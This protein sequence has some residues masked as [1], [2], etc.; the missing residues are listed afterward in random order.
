L[1]QEA[2]DEIKKKKES[3]DEFEFEVAKD[4]L[5][6]WLRMVDSH[7]ILRRLVLATTHPERTPV[8]DKVSLKKLSNGRITVVGQA[9][10]P[11]IPGA[12]ISGNEC[13]QDARVLIESLKGK[14]IPDEIPL[15]LK[16]YSDARLGP[17]TLAQ[18]TSRQIT[19]MYTKAA[20]DW[21][22][23]MEHELAAIVDFPIQ[24]LAPSSGYVHTHSVP[25]EEPERS[26]PNS[27]V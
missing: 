3:S 2:A 6:R 7:E 4:A 11:L 12:F 25:I 10:H 27:R 21:D 26:R 1:A 15:A 14:N 13:V 23:I 9:A 22:K 5:G 18:H 20:V 16:E 8:A 17:G 19:K 24:A